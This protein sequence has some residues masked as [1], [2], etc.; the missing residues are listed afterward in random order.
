MIQPLSPALERMLTERVLERIRNAP[1]PTKTAEVVAVAKELK[2]VALSLDEVAT[3]INIAEP[4]RDVKAR[5]SD[6]DPE[7]LKK[8]PD[9]LVITTPRGTFVRYTG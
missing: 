1:K 4:E 2:G 8:R 3:I 6:Y 7:E 9:L 5:A